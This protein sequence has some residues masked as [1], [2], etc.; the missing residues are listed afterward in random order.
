MTTTERYKIQRLA[1]SHN[2]TSYYDDATDAVV[3]TLD[4]PSEDGM[5]ES[6]EVPVYSI[7]DMT[8]LLGG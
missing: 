4:Y 2:L 6:E 3:V 1:T 5:W 7:N 8:D